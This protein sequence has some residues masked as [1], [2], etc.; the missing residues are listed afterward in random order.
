MIKILGWNATKR[1]FLILIR[2]GLF[3]NV[4]IFSRDVPA[5]NFLSLS[6]ALSQTE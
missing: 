2:L 6:A 4:A 5:S 1:P 3:D